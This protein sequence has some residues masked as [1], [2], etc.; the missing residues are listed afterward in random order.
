MAFDPAI[1]DQL[2]QLTL[3]GAQNSQQLNSAL[4]RNLVAAINTVLTLGVQLTHMASLNQETSIDPMEAASAA[5]IRSSQ[6]PSHFAGLN[7]A[8]GI[9]RSG[10]ATG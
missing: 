1:A 4:D 5:N 8:A 9:P 3:A 6:D 2:T 7:T 10:M